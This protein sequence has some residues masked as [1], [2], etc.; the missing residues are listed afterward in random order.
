MERTFSVH[1]P[2]SVIPNLR[3]LIKSN[4]TPALTKCR[5]L[6][7]GMAYRIE[8]LAYEKPNITSLKVMRDNHIDYSFKA[9]DRK[10]L[11]QLYES[12]G[13][14]DDIVIVKDDTVTDSYFAN[15]VFFDGQ[16]W[17][18]PDRPLLNGVMRQSLLDSGKITT[19]EVRID[20]IKRFEKVS[21][22]NAMIDLGEIEIQIGQLVK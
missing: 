7:D 8:Y 17:I 12:K 19:A 9:T 21:L 11:T 22:V 3:E 2:G 14:A 13:S 18:T 1:F 6:Y 20:E 5:F 10:K 4:D 16:N 15:L